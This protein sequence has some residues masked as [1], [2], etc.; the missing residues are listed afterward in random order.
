MA[1]ADITRPAVIQAIS[2]FDQLGRSGFLDKYGFGK[3]VDYFVIEDQHYY[4]SKALAGAAHGYIGEGFSPLGR[5]DFSGGED[6]VRTALQDLGFEI[7]NAERR[8]FIGAGPGDVLSNAELVHRFRVGNMGGMRRNKAA[9]HLVLVSDPSKGLYDDRLQGDVLHYTGEGK[10]GDQQLNKQN[11]TLTESL[12]TG[13]VIHLFEVLQPK[14]YTYVGEVELIDD[15]YQETQIDDQGDPR[16]VWMFPLKPKLGS[17]RT[18]PTDEQIKEVT[19]SREGSVFKLSNEELAKRAKAARGK[20]GKRTVTA[21]QYS[22]DQSVVEHVKRLAKGICDLCGEEAPFIDKKKRPYLECHHIQHLAKGGDDAISNAVAL[23]PNC[24]RKMHTL[25]RKGD[26]ET[27][28]V[29]VE[30]RDG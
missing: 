13:E 24:H 14:Q 18:T 16:L 11:R 8:P 28:Q 20:P 6:T 5:L 4:D 10:I 3:A 19:K 29:R 26:I 21:E 7:T 25:N 2:E 17:F 22:R 15:P 23:C 27:L 30:A 1:L 9:R 12:D